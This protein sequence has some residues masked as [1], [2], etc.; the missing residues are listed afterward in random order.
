MTFNSNTS[1]D[2]STSLGNGRSVCMCV[3]ERERE[4]QRGMCI[5][6]CIV[7]YC[8]VCVFLLFHHELDF[9]VLC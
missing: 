1:G 8:I 2:E 4:R 7:L 9:F 3:R 6:Y 5:A